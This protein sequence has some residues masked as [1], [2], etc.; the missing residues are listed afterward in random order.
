MKLTATK[1]DSCII[2]KGQKK[3]RMKTAQD[4]LLSWTWIQGKMKSTHK[5]KMNRVISDNKGYENK[6]WQDN[7]IQWPEVYFK[8]GRCQKGPSQETDFTN[9][10]L[11]THK[12]YFLTALLKNKVNNFMCFDICIYLWNPHHRQER[13][14][15]SRPSMFSCPWV[16]PFSIPRQ[17]VFFL[18][19]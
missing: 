1:T 4:Y 17:L 2:Y 3:I 15:S 7:L 10:N 19:L 9:S 8:L 5:L 14:Y 13:T 16:I 11:N 6:I 18:S 12:K